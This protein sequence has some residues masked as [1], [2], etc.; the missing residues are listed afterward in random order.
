MDGGQFPSDYSVLTCEA[1]QGGQRT[2]RT[3]LDLMTAMEA[4][5]AAGEEWARRSRRDGGRSGAEG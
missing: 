1:Y 5:R 4:V 3:D 2:N